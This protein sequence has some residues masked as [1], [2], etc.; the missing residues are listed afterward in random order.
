[1]SD[2]KFLKSKSYSFFSGC[3]EGYHKRRSYK[4][5]KGR[6]VPSRC[7]RSTTTK[8]ETSKEFKRGVTA[9]QTRRLSAAKEKLLPSIRS[10]SRRACPP[11]M[12]ERKE[13]ARK[14]ST[15]VMRKGFTT[16]K[17]KRY[18]HKK[19]LTYVAPVCIKDV[20]LPGKGKQSIGPLRKGELSKYGYSMKENEDVRHKALRKAIQEY[21]ALGVYRKLDAVAKL[22]E[23]TI[24]EAS[25]TYTKDR[26]WVRES[27][28]LKAF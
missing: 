12:I 4:S 10:L 9:K 26:N 23:R 27:F 11:G 5:V 18:P 2:H 21:G 15:A 13:Y 16:R 3:P 24:P 1:M 22:T 17:G 19:N 7:V 25:K 20:G 6:T 14:Y 8:S 28:N